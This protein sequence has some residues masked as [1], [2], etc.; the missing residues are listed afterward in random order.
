MID[1][2]CLTRP[3]PNWYQCSTL[4]RNSDSCIISNV[5]KFV[6]D[7]VNWSDRNLHVQNSSIFLLNEKC[8]IKFFTNFDFNLDI[9]YR[10]MCQTFD[11]GTSRMGPLDYAL[12][13]VMQ[14][15]LKSGKSKSK[16]LAT[17]VKW[18]EKNCPSREKF[19]Q[20]L[21]VATR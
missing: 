6:V 7:K 12:T 16:A 14:Q 11:M 17:Y 20:K 21:I 13:Y 1:L 18:L 15:I 4:P 2:C 9:N 5:V 10:L 3:H 19:C 8:A